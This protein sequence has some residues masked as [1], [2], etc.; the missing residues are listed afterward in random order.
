MCLHHLSIAGKNVII[1]DIC[2]GQGRILPPVIEI[3]KH[4]KKEALQGKIKTLF[5]RFFQK[6]DECK[7]AKMLFIESR[8]NLKNTL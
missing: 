1:A 2:G 6:I 8:R 3:I 5:V 7:N 4:F